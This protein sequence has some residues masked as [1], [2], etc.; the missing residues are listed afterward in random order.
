MWPLE[1]LGSCCPVARLRLQLGSRPRTRVASR[2]AH[3][4]AVGNQPIQLHLRSFLSIH[5]AICRSSTY[6]YIYIHTSISIYLHPHL[7]LHPC[8]HI[9]LSPYPYL[10]LYLCL[11]IHLSISIC[12]YLSIYPCIYNYMYASIY[13]S[14][15]ADTETDR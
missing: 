7:Y 13:L 1:A 9:Y 14:R 10:Y 4:R 3:G 8:L 6:I 5:E 2:G 15:D 11:S 12:L